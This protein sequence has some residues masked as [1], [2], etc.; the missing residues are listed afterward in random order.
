MD[1]T[2]LS[3]IE[4]ATLDSLK[5]TLRQKVEEATLLSPKRSLSDAQY[6]AG[7]GVLKQGTGWLIYEDFI[8]PHASRLLGP[9][10]DSRSDVSVLEI[11]PGPTSLLS[12][13]PRHLRHKV[14]KYKAFEPNSLFA[15]RLEESLGP[16]PE[17]EATFPSLES[18]PDIC[19]QPFDVE[20]KKGSDTT[21]TDKPSFHDDEKYDAIIFCHSMYGMKPK[22]MFIERA[23]K[24]LTGSPYHLDEGGL[25]LVFHRDN[26]DLHLGNL[27]CYQTASFPNGVVC[28]TDNDDEL[29]A[30]ASFV[31]GFSMA[32]G[33]DASNTIRAEWR[34]E[35]RV[36]ARRDE[37]QPGVLLFSSPEIMVAFTLCSN[38]LRELEDMVPLAES[39][40]T[41]KNREALLHHPLPVVQPTEIEHVQ[42][43]VH[44]A[45]ECDLGLT[46]VGGGHSGHCLWPN[47]V[48]VDM[49][50]FNQ[51]HIVK[52]DEYE[53]DPTSGSLVVVGAGCK[54]GDVISKTM[55][56]GLT[57]PLG[58]RPSVGAGMWL[59]GGIGHLARLY[60]LTCDA[61]VGAVIVSVE[62]HNQ[63]LCI[64]QVPSQHQPA[65]SIK[66]E[67]DADLLWAIKGAGT[68]FG[69]VTS[70]VFQPYEA[71]TYRS[72]NWVVKL[73]D[74]LKAQKK[75]SEFERCI[76]KHPQRNISADAYLYWEGGKLRLGVTL[77][78]ASTSETLLSSRQ[79]SSFEEASSDFNFFWGPGDDLEV[80]DGVDLFDAEMYVSRMHGGHG[81]GKT[82]SFKRCVFLKH[83]GE[84]EIAGHL[85][86]AIESRPSPLCYLHL[87]QG[88]G[89]V[90]DVAPD[91]TAF[92]CRDWDFACVITGVWPR[93]QDGTAVERCAT[94]WVYD[95]AEKLLESSDCHGA[96]GADL[97]PDPRDSALATK[98]FGPNRR[99][100][101]L[102]KSTMDPRDVLAYACP[103]PKISLEQTIIILVTGESC[104][105]KDFSADVWVSMLHHNQ[106][107]ARVVSISSATKREY[108]A[109]KGADL[110][111]LL[112]DRAYKEQH[113]PALTAFFKN[114]EMERSDL[115]EQQFLSVVRSAGDVD[116]L[117]ITGMR[118]EAPLAA[119]SHLVPECRLLEV[120][121]QASDQNRLSR[122]GRNNGDGS[123]KTSKGDSSQSDTT[124][125][126][127][128][129]SLIF[130]NDT[131]GS[132]AA[133]EFAEK[134]LF[135]FLRHE[136][137]DLADMV[138]T[139]ADFPRQGIEFRHVLGI[140][141][142]YGGLPLATSLLQSHFVGDWA[143]V[144]S[145]AS[146]EA[147]SFIF[148]S[149]LALQVNVPL[150]PIRKAGK[151]P[152]P[153]V[154]VTKKPSY[155]SSVVSDDAQEE[156]IELE[157]DK[158]PKG[159]DAG[160]VVV[161]DVLSK[162]ETLCAV[163]ELLKKAGVRAENVSIM[164]VAEF[165]AH[166]GRELLRQRGF[167]RTS[168]QSLLV[169]GG[170]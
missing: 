81:G 11:G 158:V 53:K 78:E 161:D 164:V 61:I 112:W 103:L 66:P 63:V 109:A 26:G 69:I 58:A 92:G 43:A 74:G 120:Y 142:E 149:A 140:V 159:P 99:D 108:A 129:P 52:G 130:T 88:G 165:P 28:V 126:P 89:A 156:R 65:G 62:D 54:T 37:D 101:A 138:G 46:V 137:Q 134:H 94:Q 133:E 168:V 162:G 50:A 154:S 2:D 166:R 107:T 157:L 150:L 155:V 23:L 33:T 79:T 38:W 98:A 113:R 105:G 12:Y 116:V 160:V 55:A 151:L 40:R 84:S 21:R 163:L 36:L 9:L 17:R 31:A 7:L 148:A 82:S 19:R 18:P 91:A 115:P 128:G 39:Q 152:P 144:D 34:K 29:D 147:G 143:T 35:C 60:G 4:M 73:G 122:G 86:A 119:S 87:L 64:G 75:I 104:A 102:L 27:A 77:F 6:S 124:V 139:V 125:L 76:T 57:V 44:W 146:C 95:N 83:I 10:F 131:P 22:H 167:G 14:K 49:G 90:C 96:Y 170:A 169:F 93:D 42:G 141:Q 70:V 114:Q 123:N 5:R 1:R 25:I 32:G 59:L 100:L 153:T 106:L 132:E 145:I 97:G 67:N 127:Y 48:S 56:E 20:D 136:L 47:V 16:K 15:V 8:I 111:R 51:V 85:V 30:F 121:V 72:R 68:N 3:L 71:P 117:L 24:M 13:L 41:V 135:P 118:D 80:T 110:G 45:L